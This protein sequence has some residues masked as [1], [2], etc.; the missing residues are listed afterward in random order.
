MPSFQP[1]FIIRRESQELVYGRLIVNL[2]GEAPAPGDLDQQVGPLAADLIGKS[3]HGYVVY[4]ARLFSRFGG[5]LMYTFVHRPRADLTSA[6]VARSKAS[7]ARH[8]FLR[9]RGAHSRG[10]GTCVALCRR[11]AVRGSDTPRNGGRSVAWLVP[12]NY[13][14]K[15]PD[16][17][18]IPKS[19]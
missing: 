14:A 19:T 3:P 8:R 7:E 18:S 13:F 2:F 4:K 10:T 15:Q 1:L 16:R 9:D 17:P 11:E 6:A 5:R 12:W